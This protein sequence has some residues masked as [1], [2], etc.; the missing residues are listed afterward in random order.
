[1]PDSSDCVTDLAIAQAVTVLREGRIVVYPTETFYGLAADP[2]SSL[3]MERLFAMKGREASKTVALIAH[4][5]ASALALASVVPAIA[6]RLAAR[7][8]PGPLTLVLPARSGL[9]DCLIGPDGG[10]G[11]R[12]SPHPIALAL[13]TGFGRPITATSA[14][15][16]GQSPTTTLASARGAFGDSVSVYLD[17]G[18]LTAPTPSTVIACDQSGWR[19]IRPGAISEAQI[20]AVLAASESR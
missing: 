11:V 14:N 4:D 3:A 19:I 18:E 16:A 7:F 6:R 15:L 8:W 2:F 5:R 1:M 17:G 9:H 20:I 10:V 12:V 13:V